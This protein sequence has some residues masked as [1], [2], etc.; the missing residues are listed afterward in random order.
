MKRIA[1]YT[2]PL[3]MVLFVF[4]TQCVLNGVTRAQTLHVTPPDTNGIYTL[5]MSNTWACTVLEEST[6][7]ASAN[8]VKCDKWHHYGGLVRS[9]RFSTKT[10][11]ETKFYRFR[12]CFGLESQN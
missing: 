8:W 11:A 9:Y 6:N 1:Y 4:A 10:N 12:E 5:A 2:L 7:L 3:W